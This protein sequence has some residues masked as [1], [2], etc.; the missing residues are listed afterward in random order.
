MESAEC[1]YVLTLDNVQ[2]RHTSSVLQFDNQIF[3]E[4]CQ[5]MLSSDQ[6]GH[7]VDHE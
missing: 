5:S 1:L 2:S 6:Y 7:E 3:V 4:H